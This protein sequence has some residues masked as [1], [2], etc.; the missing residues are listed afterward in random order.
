MSED[1]RTFRQCGDEVAMR[2]L[3]ESGLCIECRYEMD[4]RIPEPQEEE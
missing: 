2:D 3:S 4:K 1:Y